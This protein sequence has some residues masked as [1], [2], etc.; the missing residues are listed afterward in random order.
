MLNLLPFRHSQCSKYRHQFLRSEQT[1]QI[2]FQRNEELGFTRISL[3]AGTSTQLII[4]TAGL[5]PFCTNDLQTT[6]C[7]RI[8][9]KLDIG[10]ST[11]HICSDRYGTMLTCLRNDL[12][13][14][15]MEF[16]I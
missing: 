9:V 2:I 13:L 1:H 10:S 7:L 15:F 14:K 6:G 3:T 12:S 16:C 8:I 11:S 5:M 4:N